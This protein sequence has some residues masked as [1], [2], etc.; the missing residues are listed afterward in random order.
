[1]ASV[2]RSSTP[3][4]D[5]RLTATPML[6]LVSPPEL[7]ALFSFFVALSSSVF[8]FLFCLAVQAVKKTVALLSLSFLTVNSSSSWCL[9]YGHAH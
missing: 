4:V 3:S 8:I 1:M 7:P 5:E 9:D 2:F 6:T